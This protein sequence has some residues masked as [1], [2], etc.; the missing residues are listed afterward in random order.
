MRR[1]LPCW[2]WRN[3]LERGGGSATWSCTPSTLHPRGQSRALQKKGVHK[4]PGLLQPPGHP[5]GS[6]AR[7]SCSPGHAEILARPPPRCTHR[8]PNPDSPPAL[9]GLPVK[10]VL[11][12][13]QQRGAGLE[14]PSG[15]PCIGASPASRQENRISHHVPVAPLH[16]SPSPGLASPGEA[17]TREKLPPGRSRDTS[18]WG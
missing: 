14:V 15:Q 16:G 10:R 5:S 4:H 13:W 7:I 6:P 3:W 9:G 11:Q 17:P 1:A 12:W 2:E 18:T 8:A